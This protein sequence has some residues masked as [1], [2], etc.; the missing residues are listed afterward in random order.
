MI[1][2][3]FGFKTTTTVQIRIGFIGDSIT[4]GT[5]DVPYLDLYTPLSGDRKPDGPHPNSELDPPRA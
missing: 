5:G 3:P 1:A 4:H 2:P